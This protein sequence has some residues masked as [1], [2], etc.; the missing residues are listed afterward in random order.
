MLFQL[1]CMCCKKNAAKSERKRR[2]EK[3]ERQMSAYKTR[4]T[5]EFHVVMKFYV[6]VFLFLLLITYKWWLSSAKTIK[7]LFFNFLIYVDSHNFVN[8]YMEF[9]FAPN[10]IV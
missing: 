9:I 6:N 10:K 2:E 4:T 5:N 3:L 8:F 1:N 7:T